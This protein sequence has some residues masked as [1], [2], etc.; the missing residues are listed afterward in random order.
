LK[1]IFEASIRV[2]SLFSSFVSYQNYFKMVK[3]QLMAIRD[4]RG[5]DRPIQHFARI[6]R[7]DSVGYDDLIRLISKMSSLNYGVIQGVIGTLIDVIEEQVRFGRTVHLGNLGT[8][9]MTLKSRSTET[10]EDFENVNIDG[11]RLR[12]LPSKKLKSALRA[13]S[14]T[15]V[16]GE[17]SSNGQSDDANGEASVRKADGDVQSKEGDA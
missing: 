11:A 2:S 16:N 14:F 9:Y 8:L 10:A 12:F 1:P 4:P 13:L 5:A 7:G 15:R 17:E 3:Y 6:I